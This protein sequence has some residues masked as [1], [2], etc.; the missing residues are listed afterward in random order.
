MNQQAIEIIKGDRDAPDVLKDMIEGYGRE[1]RCG[2][3][4]DKLR[5]FRP[6]LVVI[7]GGKDG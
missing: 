3:L 4:L 7:Q 5:A 6:Q 1:V 2:Y